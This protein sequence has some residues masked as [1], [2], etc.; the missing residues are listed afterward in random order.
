MTSSTPRSAGCAARRT[1]PSSRLTGLGVTALRLMGVV[2]GQSGYVG[3]D[4]QAEQQDQRRDDEQ[5]RADACRPMVYM[6][7]GGP[8][9]RAA[10][11]NHGTRAVCADQVLAAHLVP[12]PVAVPRRTWSDLEPSLPVSP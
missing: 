3:D 1:A 11:L 9:Y 2:S 8:A 6:S 12:L 4:E 5:L 7:A 10:S